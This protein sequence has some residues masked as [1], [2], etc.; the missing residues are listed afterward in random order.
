M[1]L[2]TRKKG[3]VNIVE[4]SGTMKA[5]EELR[6]RETMD[7]LLGAHERFYVFDLLGVPWMDTAAITEVVAAQKHATDKEGKVVLVLNKKLHDIFTYTQLIKVFDVYDD[8]EE[9][10]GSLAR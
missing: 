4:C 6:L 1:N 2:K 10:L 7:E 5:R 9:A 3:H 8:V